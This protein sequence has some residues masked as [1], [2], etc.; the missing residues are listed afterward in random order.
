M[1]NGT[2][3]TV[4]A[5]TGVEYVEIYFVG[6]LCFVSE[7]GSRPDEKTHVAIVIAPRHA[8]KVVINDVNDVVQDISLDAG[9]RLRIDATGSA[10]RD[11]FFSLL[12]PPLGNLVDGEL[13]I[14]VQTAGPR[15][16]AVY[17]PLCTGNIHVA[18]NFEYGG[19]YELGKKTT[20]YPCAAELTWLETTTPKLKITIFNKKYPDGLSVETKT[21]ALLANGDDPSPSPAPLADHYNDLNYYR[22]ITEG[23][24]M[25]ANAKTSDRKCMNREVSNGKYT[26]DV[27]KHGIPVVD[28]E[29]VSS[30]WP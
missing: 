5:N 29:C 21:W 25:A 6:L 24:R 14:R 4:M 8:A 2:E 13:D 3:N 7:D 11:Y 9:D 16:E 15:Y 19:F 27:I 30:Q 18:R 20:T 26:A 28:V 1:N 22:Y 17:M 12:V 23:S 10:T